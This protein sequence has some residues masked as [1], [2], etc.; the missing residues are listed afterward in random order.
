MQSQNYGN[1]KHLCSLWIHLQ[2]IFSINHLVTKKP[3]NSDK[4]PSYFLEFFY[5]LIHMFEQQYKTQ[6]FAFTV[7]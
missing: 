5:L 7:I 1:N 4:S 3:T 6:R 2:T